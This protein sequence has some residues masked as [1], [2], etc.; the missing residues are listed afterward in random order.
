MPIYIKVSEREEGGSWFITTLNEAKGTLDHM[1]EE[2][3]YCPSDDRGYY[4]QAVEL[5]EEEFEALPDF[6]GF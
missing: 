6:G 5:T 4:F 1:T 3:G 2:K